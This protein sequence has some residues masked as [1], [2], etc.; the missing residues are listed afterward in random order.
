MAPMTRSSASSLAPEGLQPRQQYRETSWHFVGPDDRSERALSEEPTS[1]YGEDVDMGSDRD[2]EDDDRQLLLEGPEDHED[3]LHPLREAADRVGREV[4]KFA[5][6]LDG[7]TIQQPDGDEERH[8]MVLGLLDDYHNIAIETVKR[9]GERHDAERR[10]RAG[11]RQRKRMRG[12]ENSGDALDVDDEDQEYSPLPDAPTDLADLE[13]WEQEARTWDLLRRLVYLRYAPANTSQQQKSAPELHKY[14]SGLELWD[15]FLETDTLALERKTV[16][17]WL[18]DTAKDDGEPIDELV[19]ELQQNAERGDIIAHGW[20]HTKEAVKKEKRLHAWSKPLDLSAPELKAFLNTSKTALLVTQL[21]PDAS[22][23]QHRK[24]EV[25]D[26][27]FERAIWLG[28][29]EMLRRGSTPAEIREWCVERSQVWRAV[30]MSG[31]PEGDEEDA[32]IADPASWTLWRRTC[33]ALAR[34]GGGASGDDF[35]RAVYGILSG[36]ITS[37]ERVCGSWDD[38]VFVHYNALLRTQFDNYLQNLP[39]H[40][41]VPATISNLGAFDAVQFHGEPKGAGK[42]LIET[43]RNDSRTRDEASTPMKMLQGVLIADIF[44]DFIHQQGL[45]IS[46]LANARQPSNVIPKEKTHPDGVHNY[47]GTE[48]HDSLR[49]LTHV[50]LVFMHLGLDLGG[51][52]RQTAVENVIVSYISFLRFSGKEELIPLYCSQLEGNRKYAVLSRMLIDVTDIEQRITHI[53]NMREL[54]INVQEFVNKQARYLFADFPDREVNYPALEEFKLFE[55]SG[56]LK[57]DFIGEDTAR[58]PR[59]DVLLIRSFEWYLLVEGLWSETFRV[60]TML[61]LRFFK[62]MHLLSAKCLLLKI[63]SSSIA[64]SKTRALIGEAVDF[65]SLEGADDD[66]TEVLDGSADRRRYLK[67]HLV[68]QAKSFRELE[69]LTRALDLIETVTSFETILA[70]QQASNNEWNPNARK[71]LARYCTLQPEQMQPL[72]NKWLL[73]CPNQQWEVEFTQLREAYLPEIILAYIKTLQFAGSVLTRNFLMEC[74]DLTALMAEEKSDVLQLFQ[75]TGRMQDLVHAFTDASKTLL[76][77]SSEK[78]GTR[79]RGKQARAKG[80][81]QDLWNVKS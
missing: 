56:Q 43:L 52:W 45:A 36:D 21:D 53:R 59:I 13:R 5:E 27:Y 15:N 4:E 66:M 71:E 1:S 16:L 63:P 37:V 29:Y 69:T 78:R 67:R 40:K 32:E 7:Y 2:E 49:V 79:S 48:D 35:E 73:T 54:G 62:H 31:L 28:C 77:I 12:I 61:Y 17:Q 50:L 46:K 80:W 34:N 41:L 22:T 44:K 55:S 76:L 6:V 65:S 42:R 10:E 70:E 68:E 39:F 14:S 20:I 74:M 58:L 8:G 9:L 3:I 47:I 18:K 25:Q 26:Q 33:F 81:D 60:G 64:F 75:K 38:F 19:K 24:L 23:R 30:S 11:L 72:F 51:S 57:S